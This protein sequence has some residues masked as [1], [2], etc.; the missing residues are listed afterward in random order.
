MG[1]L[2]EWKPGEQGVKLLLRMD[3]LLFTVS[4]CQIARPGDQD[5]GMSSQYLQNSQLSCLP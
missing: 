5:G 3:P 2:R 1:M 4:K